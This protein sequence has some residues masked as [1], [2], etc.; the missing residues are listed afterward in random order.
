MVYLPMAYLYGKKF[1]GPI[2]PIILAL[3]E[4][5]YDEPYH[6]INW[7]QSRN[8]CAKVCS[9]FFVGSSIWFFYHGLIIFY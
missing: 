4:E 2:T 9:V 6:K 8:A 1:V 7:G 3:R 5:I